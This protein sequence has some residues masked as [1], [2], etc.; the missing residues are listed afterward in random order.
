MLADMRE[1]M[2]EQQAWSDRYRE[3]AALDCEKASHEQETLKQLNDQ[4]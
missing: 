4:I 3:Q 1:Q 2:K